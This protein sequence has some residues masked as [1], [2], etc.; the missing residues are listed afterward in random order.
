MSVATEELAH[1]VFPKLGRKTPAE[2]NVLRGQ[3]SDEFQGGISW[4]V[5]LIACDSAFAATNS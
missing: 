1:K 4:F 2:D 3:E 5:Q